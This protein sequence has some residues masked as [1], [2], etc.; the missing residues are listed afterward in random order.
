MFY[1]PTFYITKY[2]LVLKKIIALYT[3]ANETLHS[4]ACSLI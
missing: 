1:N 4:Q 2:Q 3:I